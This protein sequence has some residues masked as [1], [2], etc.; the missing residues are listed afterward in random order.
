MK[1]IKLSDEDH[2]LLAAAHTACKDTELALAYAHKNNKQ[3]Q[4]TYSKTLDQLKLKYKLEGKA[5]DDQ[6][7]LV[8]QPAQAETVESIDL[9]A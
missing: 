7:F 5:S 6:Q 1:V 2:T 9:D 4:A 3:A 8:G